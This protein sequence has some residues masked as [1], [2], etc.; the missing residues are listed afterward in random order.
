MILVCDNTSIADHFHRMISG[1]ELIEVEDENEDEDEDKPKRG[2]KPKPKKSYG[3]GLKGFAELWNQQG[4]EVTLRIDTELL[5]QAASEEPKA[6]KKEAAEELRK[7]G[8]TVGK[9]G[10]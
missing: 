10:E 1:E 9:A 8:A 6:T 2:K 3:T 5:A 7:I 4:A